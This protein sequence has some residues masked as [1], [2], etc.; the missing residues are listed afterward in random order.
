VKGTSGRIFTVNDFT[1]TTWMLFGEA[2]SKSDH[3]FH[4]PLRPDMLASEEQRYRDRALSAMA[5]LP[6]SHQP[7]KRLRARL[8]DNAAT[9]Y[10]E[11]EHDPIHR[12]S[13]GFTPQ[14][15]MYFNALLARDAE[16]EQGA[17][18][19][20]IA[21]H[22]HQATLAQLQSLCAT[23]NHPAFETSKPE[24]AF[25][26]GFTK[27][28]LAHLSLATSR[29]FPTVKH[30]KRGGVPT[31]CAHRDRDDAEALRPSAHDLLRHLCG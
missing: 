19:G 26:A 27:A 13:L 15:I 9:A 16:S 3:L 11:I 29:F 20:G 18:A 1:P 24:R 6:G 28:V 10:D 14:A 25:T 30:S 21:L 8:R 31:W 22:E 4:V 12:R 5:T 7:T 23:L 2:Y 17:A